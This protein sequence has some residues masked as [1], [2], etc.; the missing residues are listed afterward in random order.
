[1]LH[2][3]ILGYTSQHYTTLHYTTLHYTTIKYFTAVSDLGV[4]G[5]VL[6]QS[7]HLE[8]HHSNLD[9]ELKGV[10]FSMTPPYLLFRHGIKNKSNYKT[11]LVCV[12]KTK[13]AWYIIV[14]L[15]FFSDYFV[16]SSGSW[17]VGQNYVKPL[18][19][20]NLYI[21]R[22]KWG[23][24]KQNLRRPQCFF[25]QYFCSFPKEKSGGKFR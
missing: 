17:N 19:L 9:S 13:R 12:L 21:Y 4:S 18:F 5:Q 2:Y 14:V 24:K 11:P 10:S 1:M 3:T 8:C 20:K 15:T 16:V 22:D 25:K 7:Q 23:F 6:G